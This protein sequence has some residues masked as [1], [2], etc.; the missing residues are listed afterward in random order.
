MQ[1]VVAP[2]YGAPGLFHRAR[3][4]PEKAGQR[5]MR[6]EVPVRIR[7]IDSM[8]PG[9]DLLRSGCR[10]DHDPRINIV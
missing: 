8:Q 5:R 10:Q 6:K 4:R 7:D 3:S 1:A 2:G 9:C